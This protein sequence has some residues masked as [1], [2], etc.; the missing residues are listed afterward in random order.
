MGNPT[1]DSP[2]AGMLDWLTGAEGGSCTDHAGLLGPAGAKVD[3]DKLA[4]A[5]KG[6]ASKST[7]LSPAGKSSGSV[8]SGNYFDGKQYVYNYNASTGGLA[9]VYSKGRAANTPVKAGSQAYKAILAEIKSGGSK[10]I[11]SSKLKIMRQKA[12]SLPPSAPEALPSS[13][14]LAQM[15]EVVPFYKKPWFM[16]GAPVT[17]AILIG[18]GILFWPRGAEEE[19]EE[20]AGES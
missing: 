12:P 7:E 5:Q 14:E 15:A 10:P 6:P 8:P 9:I 16:V 20:E 13:G 2:Y 11:S 4:A 19:E 17:L 1:T 3:C 18:A